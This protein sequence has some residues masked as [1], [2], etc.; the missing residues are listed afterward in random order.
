L[1]SKRGQGRSLDWKPNLRRNITAADLLALMLALVFVLSVRFPET[2]I[3]ELTNY[4]IKNIFLALLV[5]GSW[6]FFLWFNGSRETNILGFGADEYK[7]LINA[8]LLSFT[9]VAFARHIEQLQNHST[10]LQKCAVAFAKS[11]TY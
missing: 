4:E 8:T 5:L 7:K 2:W 1:T 6:L 9:S 10:R 3:G 11:V